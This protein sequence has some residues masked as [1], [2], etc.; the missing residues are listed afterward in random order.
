MV[1]ADYGAE[2]IKV[3]PP[4]GDPAQDLP[5][6]QTWNRGKKSVTLDLKSERGREVV[7]L[8]PVVEAVGGRASMVEGC[9]S[10]PDTWAPVK[11]AARLRLT[12]YDITGAPVE[13]DADGLLA[14]VLQHE[15][16]HLEG[17]LF[18][19]RLSWWRRRRLRRRAASGA[20]G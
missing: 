2:V 20:C 17:R 19:D 11:R 13:I 16:D 10:V 4:A 9:L 15:V 3:E 1:L 6:F 14:I 18:V 7:V 5:A 8:N 12:G